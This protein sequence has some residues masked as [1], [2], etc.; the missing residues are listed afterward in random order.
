MPFAALLVSLACTAAFAPLWRK[1]G[2]KS[3]LPLLALG[4]L[5]ATAATVA[6]ADTIT[7]H[8]GGEGCSPSC[9]L[10]AGGWPWVWVSDDPVTSPPG[11]VSMLGPL[12]GLSR[13]HGLGF[14]L[15]TLV[16]GSVIFGVG[17]MLRNRPPA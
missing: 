13:F 15:D 10:A 7:S 6:V 17:W 14:S 8:H 16:F 5:S 1:R 2:I 12:V 3:A 4:A 9:E 11:S